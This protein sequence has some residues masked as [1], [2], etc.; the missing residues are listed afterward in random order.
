MCEHGESTAKNN[1]AAAQ[2]D[3]THQGSTNKGLRAKCDTSLVFVQLGSGAE[4][5]FYIFK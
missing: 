3:E 5:D 4:D 1:Y 2:N